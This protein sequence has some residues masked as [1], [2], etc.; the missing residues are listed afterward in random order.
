LRLNSSISKLRANAVISR[1]F[2][3]RYTRPILA[4]GVC[5]V[6]HGATIS[7]EVEAA[8]AE[9]YPHDRATGYAEGDVRG[10]FQPSSRPAP[11]G[12]RKSV[13]RHVHP[14]DNSS[15]NSRMASVD[16]SKL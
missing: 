3:A 14:L 5:L 8:L 4:G 15:T 10:A 11:G 2:G 9:H 1:P 13:V 16:S 12:R 6:C 7:D